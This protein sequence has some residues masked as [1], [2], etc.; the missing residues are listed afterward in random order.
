[1]LWYVVWLMLD[2]SGYALPPLHYLSG[3]YQTAAECVKAGD[4]TPFPNEKPIPGGAIS[5][6]CA[7]IDDTPNK[8]AT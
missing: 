2:P 3:P 6:G 1:M 5:I 8:A 4:A 7:Q